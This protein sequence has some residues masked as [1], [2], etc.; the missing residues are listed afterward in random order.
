MIESISNLANL[1]WVLG[2]L[3]AAETSLREYILH[4][5]PGRLAYALA[6]LAG[7]LTERGDLVTALEIARQ[8][9]PT[10]NEKGEAWNFMDHLALRSALAGRL[11]E[12]ARLRGYADSVHETENAAREPNEAR[13]RAHLLRLLTAHFDGATLE[14]LFEEGRCL[15]EDAACRLALAG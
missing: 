5:R 4:V 3:A 14:R 8:A 7:V 13:A 2:E 12:A 10:L 6:N 15:S 11:T 9:I 1:S